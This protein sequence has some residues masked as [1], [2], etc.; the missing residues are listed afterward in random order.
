MGIYCTGLLMI[1]LF[2]CSYTRDFLNSCKSNN[3]YVNL[4]GQLIIAESGST[5]S[6][7]VTVLSD[8]LHIPRHKLPEGKIAFDMNCTSEYE[9][10][11][12][13][14]IRGMLVLRDT[15][16]SQFTHHEINEMINFACLG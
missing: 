9:E 7:N 8:F 11:L 4:C 12:A 1:Y 14:D 6:N 13:G 10:K 15:A 3:S 2:T 5:A 16:S